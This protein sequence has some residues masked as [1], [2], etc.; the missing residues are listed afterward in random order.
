MCAL[1][2]LCYIN[3]IENIILVSLM[4]LNGT[5]ISCFCFNKIVNKIVLIKILSVSLILLLLYINQQ[6]YFQLK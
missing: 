5:N 1:K 4:T 2:K 6:D 3:S